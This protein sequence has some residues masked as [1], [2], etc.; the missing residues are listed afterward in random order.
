MA[1]P[2][3]KVRAAGVAVL[4]LLLGL[5]SGVMLGR[6]LAVVPGAV[7][8]DVPGAMTLSVFCGG[9]TVHGQGTTI[10]FLARDQRCDIEAALSPVMPLRG[11]VEIGD[12]G[13]YRCRR[14]GTELQCAGPL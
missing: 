8:L 10:Q 3:P 11:T 5:G 2:N 4:G 14:N 1:D 12:P 7:D 9:T 6:G 13:R